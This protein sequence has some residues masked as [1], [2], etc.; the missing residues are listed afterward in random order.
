[1]F[2]FAVVRSL[3][4]GVCVCFFFSFCFLF[5]SVHRAATERH[6]ATTRDCMMGL[7]VDRHLTALEDMATRKGIDTP[8]IFTDH[9]MQVMRDIRLST[10]TL[11]SPAL[12][13]G[14]FGPVSRTR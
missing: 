5:C 3:T 10:S 9:A 1:M 8:A 7:G 12:A 14:G 4:K 6:M 2:C 11:A 13:G